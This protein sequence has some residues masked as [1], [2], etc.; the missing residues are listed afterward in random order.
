MLTYV[1][2]DPNA[3][4]IGFAEL[5]AISQYRISYPYLSVLAVGGAL[6]DRT[7]VLNG[8]YEFA[9]PEVLFY[10]ASNPSSQVSHFLTFLQSRSETTELAALDAGF[11]PCA[12]LNGAVAGDRSS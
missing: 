6:P 10:T 4:A 3:I 1:N 12:D 5:D 11:I 9:V 2:A 7:D 8:S